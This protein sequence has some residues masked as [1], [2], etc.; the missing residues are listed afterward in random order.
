LGVI[1]ELNLGVTQDE[2]SPRKGASGGRERAD[3][4]RLACSHLLL[5][6]V[7]LD[8][9]QLEQV[10][11]RRARHVELWRSNVRFCRGRFQFQSNLVWDL[12]KPVST[13][14]LNCN[15]PIEIHNTTVAAKPHLALDAREPR[16]AHEQLHQPVGGVGEGDVRRHAQHACEA[17]AGS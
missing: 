1:S 9:L 15:Q 6:R 14:A 10:G 3:G 2:A 7:L 16:V 4:E 11:E 12:I 13:F 5:Q 8:V 17:P